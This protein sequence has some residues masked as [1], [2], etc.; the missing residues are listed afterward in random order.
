M[1]TKRGPS[2]N[3]DSAPVRAVGDS[4]AEVADVPEV[5]VAAADAGRAVAAVA[6]AIAASPG[7][8]QLLEFRWGPTGPHFY[9]QALR[10][11][12]GT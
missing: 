2:P 1:S 4:A 9:F 5:V 8:S 11:P 10:D 3:A 7:G 12:H 6:A